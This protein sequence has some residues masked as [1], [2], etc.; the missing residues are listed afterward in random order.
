MGT[1]DVSAA[2]TASTEAASPVGDFTTWV[3][4]HLPVMTSLAARLVTIPA[5]RDD[6]V[7][8]ALTAA[9]RKRE[10]FDAARGTPRAWLLAIVADQARKTR[11]RRRPAAL[12][13]VPVHTD[14][15]VDVDLERAVRAL[16]RRQRLAVELHYF[17]DLPVAEV[18]TAMDC[19]PGTVKATL[20]HARDHLHHDLGEE[21][22]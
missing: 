11:R 3:G 19:S 16:P 7:Q 21:P 4:P 22:S 15:T 1:E 18:A 9:W 17:L 6:A 20:S 2:D 14:R 10:T 5:D 13:T 8:E 12:V